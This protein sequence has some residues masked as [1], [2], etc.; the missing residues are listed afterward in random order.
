MKYA[1]VNTKGGVGKTTNAI[2]LAT[3]LAG[4]GSALLI[5]AD[6]QAS[7]AS[8]AAWRRDAERSP[9]PTT[10]CLAGRAVFDEG[11][12]L[13]QGFENTVIDA[14]GR[15]SSGLRSALLLADIAIVPVGASD[16]D[17]ASMTDL[18]EITEIAK[19]FNP[20]LKIRVLLSRVSP[21]PHVKDADRMFEW[22]Q[23]NELEVLSARICERVAYRRCIG[24]GAVVSEW[25]KDQHAITEMDQFL[26]EVT[27]LGDSQ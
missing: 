2:H 11:R 25:K 27:N 21:Q 10:T 23:E 20:D 15:D 9:S 18:L 19:D 8:W 6:P 5:D 12:N 7:G 24:E 4:Q 14:G 1:I 22:L 17:S 26:Q 3:H 16:L 13:S